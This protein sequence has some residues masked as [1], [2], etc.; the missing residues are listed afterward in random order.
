MPQKYD[1]LFQEW[2][3]DLPL[4]W[5]GVMEKVKNPE[6]HESKE[7]MPLW[8]FY[9]VS[10]D[11][12]QTWAG[13]KAIGNSME[14]LLAIMVDYDDGVVQ[15]AHVEH[16]FDFQFV[17]YSSPTSTPE[18]SKFRMIIPLAEPIPNKFFKCKE[19]RQYMMSKFPHCD[20]STFDYFRRQR[21]PCKLSST[22]YQYIEK[23]GD[24]IELDVA[25]MESLWSE[26]VEDQSR[27]KAEF[28]KPKPKSTGGSIFSK[29]VAEIEEGDYLKNLM[30]KYKKELAD[31]NIYVRGNGI[32]HDTLRRI[33]YSLR[34]SDVPQDEILDFVDVSLRGQNNITPEIEQLVYGNIYD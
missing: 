30:A 4:K 2:A 26:W 34:K 15:L 32:V 18:K 9:H 21:M 33:I 5:D 25:H 10:D 17:A 24:R 6:E 19:V 20:E 7:T 8:S 29:S 11:A 27:K 13:P 3:D 28:S 23:A 22:D 1:N 16:M 14:F 12:D 31:L